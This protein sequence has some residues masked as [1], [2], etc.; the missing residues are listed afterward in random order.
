MLR[1]KI[2]LDEARKNS[3]HLAQQKKNAIEILSKYKDDDTIHISYTQVNKVGINP[4]S[5]F[6]DTPIGVYAY[7]LKEIWED[8]HKEGVGNVWFAASNA[9]YIFI[10]KEKVKSLFDVKNYTTIL[11]EKEL[12]KIY[13]LS[14]IDYDRFENVVSNANKNYQSVKT[15][16]PF[17]F[18]IFILQEYGKTINRSTPQVFM[19]KVFRDLKYSGFVD[20]SGLGAIHVSEPIQ[21]VFLSPKYYEVVERIDLSKIDFKGDDRRDIPNVLKRNANKMTDDEIFDMIEND[22]SLIRYVGKPRTG[23]LKKV[24][25]AYNNEIWKSNQ[26]IPDFFQRSQIDGPAASDL[27]DYKPA[28]RENRGIQVILGTYNKLPID[29]IEWAL[30]HQ[31][32][33]IYNSMALWIKKNNVNIPKRILDKLLKE[34]SIALTLY[35]SISNK[36]A[37]LAWENHGSGF[38]NILND[39]QGKM[40]N[41]DFIKFIDNENITKHDGLNYNPPV[42]KQIYQNLLDT[43]A[44]YDEMRRFV[45]QYLGNELRFHRIDS[46]TNDMLQDIK[47]RFDWAEYTSL[48]DYIK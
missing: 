8:I 46:I 45:D 33:S 34:K 22:I 36:E 48:R 5:R 3:K 28:E 17:A 32:H 47:T 20:R 10:L 27:D 38:S 39:I 44:P 30:F 13:K 40:T 6:S 37:K 23:L 2:F 14:Y 9:K 24:A 42:A 35:K 4:K 21:S 19:S 1:F 11:L 31:N 7:P 43:K 41:K 15:K 12:K 16:T 26:T 29:F 25:M 18:L